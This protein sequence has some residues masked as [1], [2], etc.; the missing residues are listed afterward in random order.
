MKTL[1]RELK[2][3]RSNFDNVETKL[4]LT[5]QGIEELVGEK[6]ALEKTLDVLKAS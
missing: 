5:K 4:A 3:A 2:V 1:E 6:D